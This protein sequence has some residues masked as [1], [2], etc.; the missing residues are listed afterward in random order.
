MGNH[1]HSLIFFAILFSP[2]VENLRNRKTDCCDC[3]RKNV[4]KNESGY[5]HV[6]DVLLEAVGVVDVWKGG[7]VSGNLHVQEVAERLPALL[8]VEDE[9]PIGWN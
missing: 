7:P 6:P 8:D 3:N 5:F 4:D 2:E 1:R 9:E